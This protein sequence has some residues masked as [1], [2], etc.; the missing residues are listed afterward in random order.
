MFTH[1]KKSRFKERP[2]FKSKLEKL[3]ENDQMSFCKTF[4]SNRTEVKILVF[5]L[6]FKYFLGSNDIP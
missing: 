6:Q 1:G 5:F 4:S 2:E 3:P